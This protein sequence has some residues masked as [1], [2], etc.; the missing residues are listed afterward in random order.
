M[1]TRQGPPT[2]LP[3]K[4]KLVLIYVSSS[5]IATLMTVVSILGL[6]YCT[7]IYP[8]DD[9]IRTFVSN[10]VVNLSIGLPILLGC[11]WLAWHGKLIGLLCWAGALFFVFYDYIAY[12]FAMPLNWAFLLHLILAMLSVYTFIG[13]LANIDG[14]VVQQR[15]SGAVP[16][17]FAG[18]V[19]AGL[20]LLFLVRVISIVVNAIISG[21]LLARTELAVSLADFFITPA[22][23]I[24]GVLLWRR[25]E[26]GYVTGL[27]ML[28][29]GSMLFIALITF[30][31]LQP[32]L[33]NASF[34]IADI[35]VIF[36]MG[37][38]CFIPFALFVRGVVAKDKHHRLGEK[39]S[40]G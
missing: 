6:R 32:F 25:N 40:I 1:K 18:V 30:L 20:G 7:V 38:I 11:M 16:E 21:D 36:A 13:L 34:A 8:T 33:S 27:G 22:W 29:Q 15:L 5:L 35:V 12:V 2:T 17:K 19:L 24:V 9:L 37:L 23:I 4:G 28:F 3:I 14:K 31:L 26:L 10:D 39:S